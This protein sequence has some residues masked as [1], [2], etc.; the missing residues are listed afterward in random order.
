MSYR[1]ELRCASGCE[2]AFELDSTGY[3]CP[4]CGDLFE[5]VHDLDAL[6]DRTPDEWKRLFDARYKRTT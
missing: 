1:A 3:R 4:R 5:V 6:R 2:G